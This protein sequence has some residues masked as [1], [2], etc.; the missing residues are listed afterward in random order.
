MLAGIAAWSSFLFADG[1]AVEV[2]HAAG[3]AAGGEVAA[4][5]H[6]GGVCHQ[7]VLTL[8]PR[9]SNVVFQWPPQSRHL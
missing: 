2:G 4:A 1:L 7:S 3:L 8:G 6:G 5:D 9:T